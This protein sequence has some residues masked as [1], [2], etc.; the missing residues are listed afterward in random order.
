MTMEP[1]N[2]SYAGFWKRF[3][4]YLIDDIIL[5]VAGLAVILFVG[6]LFGLS[7]FSL[8]SDDAESTVA[9]IVAAA[10][11]I[12]LAILALMAVGWLYYAMM[13]SSSNQ[14][15]LGKMAIG[16]KVTDLEGNRI[17]FGKATGR[18][19]GKIVSGMILY[20]GF[21]MAGFTERKQALHDIMAG[22]L[23]VNK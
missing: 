6:A 7:L 17:S 12:G 18:Y 2:V 11:A 5:G 8:L 9:L 3:I 13:E 10:S 14:G 4:A 1:T 16:I 20:I 15:T 19:F 22:C 23:V 21:I